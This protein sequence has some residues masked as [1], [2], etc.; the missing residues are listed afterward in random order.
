MWALWDSQEEMP[1]PPPRSSI[2]VMRNG[3]YEPQNLMPVMPRPDVL[4]FDGF[5]LRRAAN[6]VPVRPPDLRQASLVK[7]SVSLRKATV[8]ARP[9]VSSSPCGGEG[10]IVITFVY[11]ALRAGQL[12][13]YLRVTEV[14]HN[15]TEPGGPVRRRV[16]LVQ[17]LAPSAVSAGSGDQ[18]GQVTAVPLHE[19][20]FEKGLGQVYSSP[21][22]ELQDFCQEQLRF[23]PA[24]PREIPLAISLMLDSEATSAEEVD[25]DETQSERTVHYT[26]ISLQKASLDSPKA[27]QA[28]E[29]PSWSAHVIGQKL[30]HYGQCFILHEVFGAGPTGEKRSDGAPRPSLSDQ[31]PEGH[32]DC[33]ICLSEPRDT[34]VLPCRHMCFC[35]YCAGIVRLQCDRC[36]VCR[37]K[38]QSLLQFKR[39]ELQVGEA[40]PN[41]EASCMGRR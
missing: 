37:Q 41:R 19:I 2:F 35:S 24:Q 26:Y 3:R 13:L 8:Q 4:D 16:E 18:S 9:A 29:R 7:S 6:R 21:P 30:E 5:V 14:E 22:L 33:V 39:E 10:P 34:A 27:D 20:H 38:V 1:P 12:S 11:D 15:E 28:E 40:L 23:N 36:P 31:D 17:P 25:A 32:T